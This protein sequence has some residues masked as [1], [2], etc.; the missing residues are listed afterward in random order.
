MYFK[1]QNNPDVMIVIGLEFKQ[2][3]NYMTIYIENTTS[4]IITLL[5]RY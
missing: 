4:N 1:N 2:G 5:I 3:C